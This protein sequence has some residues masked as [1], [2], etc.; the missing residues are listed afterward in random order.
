MSFISELISATK[1]TFSGLKNVVVSLKKG[2]VL[3]AGKEFIGLFK[4][5]YTNN[6]KGKYVEVKGKK[7]P[8]VAI[9]LVVVVGIFFVIPSSEPEFNEVKAPEEKKAAEPNTYEQDGIKVYGLEKCESAVCGKLENNGENYAEEIKIT[10]TFYAEENL[11]VCRSQAVANNLAP[12][13]K[14]DFSVPCEID[15]L[16]YKLSD[17]EVKVSEE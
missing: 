4:T 16:T 11:A 15:F 9:M 13:A 3:G 12:S 10:V 2:N 6:L 7:I 5:V 8:A 14:A 17:V 1:T